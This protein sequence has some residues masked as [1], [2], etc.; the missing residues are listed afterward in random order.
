[1]RKIP[2]N[3]F[4][5]FIRSRKSLLPFTNN[6]LYLPDSYTPP[7]ETVPGLMFLSFSIG[8]ARFSTVICI[9]ENGLNEGDEL[10]VELDF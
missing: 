6:I 5:S 1:M 7:K 10:K 3:S 4:R 2:E 9:R 8:N